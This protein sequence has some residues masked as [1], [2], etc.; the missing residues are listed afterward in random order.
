MILSSWLFASSSPP[1]PPALASFRQLAAS[2]TANRSTKIV[3]GKSGKRPRVQMRSDATIA[4]GVYAPSCAQVDAFADACIGCA[5]RGLTFGVAIVDILTSS[6]SG[7]SSASSNST[8]ASTSS[9]AGAT[10]AFPASQF[11]APPPTT[12]LSSSTLLASS[13]SSSLLPSSSPSSSSPS[14]STERINRTASLLNWS[15]TRALVRLVVALFP[16]ADWYIKVDV[17]SRMRVNVPSTFDPALD[18]RS[19]Y[20]LYSPLES[21]PCGEPCFDLTLQPLTS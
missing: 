3:A 5:T 10:H 14:P 16:L 9:C 18:A 21:L 15:K 7:G 8:A 2:P 13:S 19:T 17:S 1:P 6:S 11:L 20:L 4:W 12:L